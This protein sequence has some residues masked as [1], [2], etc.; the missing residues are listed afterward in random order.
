[1]LACVFK[2]CRTLVCLV[3]CLYTMPQKK[4]PSVL[5]NRNHPQTIVKSIACQTHLKQNLA[6]LH[7]VTLKHNACN[8]IITLYSCTLNIE[9]E[10][11]FWTRTSVISTQM[12]I[13]LIERTLHKPYS[14]KSLNRN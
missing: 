11:I 10:E 6:T 13:F 14:V 1:M 12:G 5:Y 9:A 8:V 3:Y 7:G 4:N 2:S